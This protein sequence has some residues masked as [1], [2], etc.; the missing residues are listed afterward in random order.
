M[1]E[2]NPR[3]PIIVPGPGEA[4]TLTCEIGG[5]KDTDILIGYIITWYKIVV[6]DKQEIKAHTITATIGGKITDSLIVTD[7]TE[8]TKYEWV[9]TIEGDKI[10]SSD[11]DITVISKLE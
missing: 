7:V 11:L 6:E 4:V 9:L 2:S 3:K 5:F 10:V 8:N 1:P